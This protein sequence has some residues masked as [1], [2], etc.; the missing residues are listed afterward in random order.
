MS[1]RA[2]LFHAS[3]IRLSM[4]KKAIIIFVI[5]GVLLLAGI[6]ALNWR[7]IFPPKPK[8]K[9]KGDAAK[10][11]IPGM[12]PDGSKVGSKNTAGR[13]KGYT[14]NDLRANV[15][16]S[17]DISADFAPE[18]KELQTLMNQADPQA[19]LTVDG[20]FGPATMYELEQLYGTGSI[21][22]DQAWFYFVTDPAE[23]AASNSMVNNIL[24]FQF[25]K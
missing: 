12:L 21:T 18:V 11:S 1:Y 4:S 15:F 3:F 8:D 23:T 19:K 24:G 14:S 2:F 9:A 7:S 5:V 22:L 10:K 13:S 17:I 16:L 20:V 25:F 6:V